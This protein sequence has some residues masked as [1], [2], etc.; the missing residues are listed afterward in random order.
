MSKQI[1]W[2]VFDRE[3]VVAV[4]PVGH[5]HNLDELFCWC[6]P[7]VSQYERPLVVHNLRAHEW[8]D[9]GMLKGLLSCRRCGIMQNSGNADGLCKGPVRVGGPRGESE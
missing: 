5:R 4:A 6:G 8:F 3:S 7:K 9:C 2:G 1:T